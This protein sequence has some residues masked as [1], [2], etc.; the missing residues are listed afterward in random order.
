M[1]PTAPIANPATRPRA[2]LTRRAA[3]GGHAGR[4]AGDRGHDL[5]GLRGAD[6]EEAEQAG[7]RAGVGEL[8]DRDRAGHRAAGLPTEELIAAVVRAGYTATAPASEPEPRATSDQPGGEADARH[9]AY[10]K[11]RLIVSL[12]L[13]IPLT[14]LS[15]M[16]SLVPSLRFPGWQWLLVG[17]AAPVALWCAWPFHRAALKNARHGTTTMDTLVSLGI[18]AACG[19]SVYAMFALDRG[20]AGG[21]LWQRLI[22]N[23]GG[24]IYLETAATVTTFLLAGRLYEARARR[25]AGQAMRDLA[26]AA[27]SEVCLLETDGTERRV[28]ATRLR[29]GDRFVVRPG[30]TIAA[31]GEVEFG[32]TAVDRSM[33]TGESVPGEA[34]EGDSVTGGTVVLTGRVVVRAVNVGRDT[35]LARLISLVEQ[36]QAQKAAIQRVADRICG[37]FVPAVLVCA[38]ATLAGW[39]LAGSPAEHAFSA[40]LA[41]LIIACPCALGLATPAALVAASGRGA[42]NGIFVKE[43]QALESS[44]AVDVVVLDKTGTVTTGRMELVG[45]PARRRRQPAPTCSGTRARSRRP[46]STRSRPRSARPRRTSAARCRWPRRSG[47]CPGSARAAPSTAGRSSS[48]APGCWPSTG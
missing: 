24:G 38:A 13:F 45:R 11:R 20:G 22:H 30:E 28:P 34:A 42:G 2:C 41:V 47:R 25:I 5:R 31:D 33:M 27:A 9:A 26:A 10:L 44:R 3:D 4:R 19:W 35:Q 37:V 23:S 12:V 7:R 6:R 21:T 40:G 46:P 15:M 8:R 36:A 1:T 32:Q 16:L 48:G 29:P 18:V 14:D 43:Y 17:C 39:L